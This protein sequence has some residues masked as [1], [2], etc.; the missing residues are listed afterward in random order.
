MVFVEVIFNLAISRSFSYSIPPEISVIPQPGQ[1]V[2]APFGTRELAGVIVSVAKKTSFPETRDINDILDEKPVISSELLQL[3]RWVAEYY[4]ASWGQTIQLAFPKKLASK[5]RRQIHPNIR[6]IS[7]L[8]DLSE[9]Q[10]HL[11]DIIFRNP[12]QSDTSYREKFGHGSFEHL[13]R[14][15]EA[16]KLIHIDSKSPRISES[17]KYTKNIIVPQDIS[18]TWT[19]LRDQKEIKSHINKY[20]GRILT[21]DVF[22]SVL[23]ITS[24]RLKTL[25]RRGI[26]SIIKEPVSS[27]PKY[28]FHE[29]QK[30]IVLSK[31]Q[32]QV[33]GTVTY[34]M[35]QNKYQVFLLHGITGSGKTQIYLE[36]IQFARDQG[37]SAIVLIPEISLT[38]QTVT[39]FENSFP[40]QVAVFHSK[41]TSAERFN[42]WRSVYNGE[43]QIVIGPRSALFMPV[44]E[45][46]I[47]VVDEEHDSSYKQSSAAPRYN[48]RDTAVY[49]ARL[50]NAVVILGSATPSLESYQNALDNKYELLK[51]PERIEDAKLPTVMT[52]DTKS[53]PKSDIFSRP[54]FEKIK[55]RLDKKEQIILLQNRRGY[56]S[57]LQCIDCGYLHI[58]PDCEITLTYHAS[59]RSLRC[60]YCGYSSIAAKD[61]PKCQGEQINYQGIGTQKI[62]Q[63]I[64]RVFPNCKVIRMDQ[65]TTIQKGAHDRILSLFREHRADILL[66]TQMIAKGLDFSNV[67]LVGVIS[68][69]I[70]LTLPDYRA[71][72]R[73]FQLLTQVSGRSGRGKIAGEVVIQ[74]TLDKHYAIQF[75]KKHDYLGFFRKESRFRQEMNY[76]PFSRL[77]N[78]RVLGED[79]Q[80]VISETRKLKSTLSRFNK[81]VFALLGPA[82]APLSKIG[83]MYRWQLLIKINRKRDPAATKTKSIL[84]P[85]LES[86]LKKKSKDIRVSVD[87]DPLELL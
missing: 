6:S 38:P 1:R 14:Q 64:R 83:G 65:D 86:F 26:I 42:A 60:H 24:Q 70:G 76:P 46:G 52:V 30:H 34:S 48:A 11:F 20:L 43:K 87:V 78:I 8:S 12:G 23:G 31:A 61:C 33:L 84:K 25:E 75:A 73:S 51:L 21:E 72:E 62:E 5:Q 66:G 56:A 13:L 50:N 57:F 40:G 67:T 68:A 16:K 18:G 47:I 17:V 74:S 63:E 29:D 35:S 80:H 2:R 69:E 54:L 82:P 77:I 15:L 53:L 79:L 81:D 22:C 27:A 45:V 32:K 39:R 41:M 59:N 37:K 3:T 10:R 4:M 7:R 44:R 9:P 71:P 49:R 36:A 58:C 28:Q 19:G 55:H 85:H